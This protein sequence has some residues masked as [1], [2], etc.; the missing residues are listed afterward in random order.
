MEVAQVLVDRGMGPGDL[1]KQGISLSLVRLVERNPEERTFAALAKVADALSVWPSEL[2][3]APTWKPPRKPESSVAITGCVRRILDERGLGP[4]ALSS[5][6]IPVRSVE[7][8]LG[9]IRKVTPRTLRAIAGA[10][11]VDV[12]DLFC[13]HEGV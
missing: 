9:N 10:I 3:G 5:K 6:G 8:A 1:A 12:R 7:L 4:D 13:E 11:G 2:F